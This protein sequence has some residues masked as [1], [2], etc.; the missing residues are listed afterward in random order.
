MNIDLLAELRA[1]GF[2]LFPGAPNTTAVSQETDQNYGPFK[3]QYAKNLDALVEARV[4]Q[5]KTTSL[6]PW[7][8]CLIVYGGTDPETNFVVENSAFQQAAFSREAC[9]AV[10]E[11]VGAAPLTRKCLGDK[12]VRKS[13]GDGVDEYEQLITLIQEANNLATDQIIFLL[14]LSKMSSVVTKDTFICKGSSITLQATGA[15]SYKWSNGIV[16]ASNSVS[17]ILLTKYVVTGTDA[18]KCVN[19]DSVNVDVKLLPI[20]SGKLILCESDSTILKANVAS[21]LL[22]TSWS[23]ADGTKA[24]IGNNGKVKAIKAG[25]TLVNYE[26]KKINIKNGDII[27]INN[28]KSGLGSN[29]CKKI[30]ENDYEWI[31]IISCNNKSFE[32]DYKILNVKYKIINKFEIFTNYL[33]NL[34]F[35]QK[36]N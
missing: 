18:N 13:I 20:I 36:N 8:V 24:S 11:K 10:W 27:L 25:Q 6:P 28:G 15:T 23:V 14:K 35:L 17:P 21:K 30:L 34:I 4:N 12:L 9:L 29:L 5:K 16:V 3:N 26:D 33:I 31:V 22:G 2:I 1:S 32:K 19:K 7:M